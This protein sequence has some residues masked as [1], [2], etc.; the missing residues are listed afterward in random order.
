MHVRKAARVRTIRIASAERC[1][2]DLGRL[3]AEGEAI[4]AITGRRWSAATLPAV[5]LEL[6]GG[7]VIARLTI[8]TLSFGR[9]VIRELLDLFD[10]GKVRRLELLASAFF[11]RHNEDLFAA[12][13]EAFEKRGQR[14]AAARTHAKVMCVRLSDGRR[15]IAE[16]SANL[17]G[18]SDREQLMLTADA[19]LYRWHVRWIEEAMRP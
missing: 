15:L 17:R 4:H 13:V 1:R 5:L 2:R 12:A 11:R 3:P 10:A 14:L 8:A 6:A 19:G 7:A 18:C 16:G 9:P